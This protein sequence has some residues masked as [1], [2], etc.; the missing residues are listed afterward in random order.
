MFDKMPMIR[1]K[2]TAS[3]VA[4]SLPLDLNQ[5]DH[6]QKECPHSKETESIK[7]KSR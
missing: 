5:N 7:I 6:H 2:L 1:S 4:S 3:I